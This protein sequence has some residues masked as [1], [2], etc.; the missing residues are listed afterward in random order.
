MSWTLG[1]R[2]RVGEFGLAGERLDDVLREIDLYFG[3]GKHG[4][5]LLRLQIVAWYLCHDTAE[6]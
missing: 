3:G 5:F 6:S 2:E 4:G 1:R